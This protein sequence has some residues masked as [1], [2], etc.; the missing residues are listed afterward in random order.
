MESELS[1]IAAIYDAIIDP[2]RWQEV[3]RRIVE[4]TRSVGGGIHI[5]QKNVV[6]LSALH[7]I[8]PFYAEAFIE[9]WHQHNPL[10]DMVA[11]MLPG[12][13]RSCTHCT[14]TDEFRA[15]AFFNEFLR[16]QGQAD[17]VGLGLLHG[18]HFSGYLCL[19]RSPEA[20]W[21]EPEEWHLLE[22]LAPHLKR[23]A[24]VHQLLSRAKTTTD[25]LG[26]AIAAAGFAAFLLT[27]DCR[28]VFANGNAEDLMLRGA[29]LRCEH[30]RLV[31]A[32][33]ALTKRLQALA[34]DAARP[35]RAQ[36][37]IGGTLELPRGEHRAPLVARVFPVAADGAASIFD[38]DRPTVAVV[39]TD[40]AADFSA[41][42]RRF[43][44]RYG[45]TPAETRM[46]AETISG[47]GLLAA[48]TKLEVTEA[49]ART[50]MKRIFDKTGVHRQAELVRRFFEASLPGASLNI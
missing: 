6:H 27:S 16:P 33:L 49:T 13:L 3:V 36:S 30:G 1:L 7:N 29:G 4:A 26:M 11:T 12:E 10:F 20:I 44:A 46:V 28:I 42:V 37:D 38:I 40:P 25:S 41:Q 21:V 5:H 8:D 18:P 47:N 35:D 9:T 17:A 23:A 15:S 31:A 43:G 19:H 2:S 34:R 22:T 48:A 24:E 32:T 50:H 14:Q 39:V 45:L